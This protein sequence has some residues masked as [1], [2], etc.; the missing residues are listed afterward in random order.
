LLIT[1]TASSFLCLFCVYLC[2]VKKQEL[3]PYIEKGLISER[4]HPNAD[5]WI[6]NYTPVVQYDRL[7]DAITKSCRGLIMDGAGNVIARPFSKFF[8]LQEHQPS[9]IPNEPFDVYEKMDG[10]LGIIY[11]IGNTPYIATRGSFESEQSIH[12]TNVLHT[13]YAH[14]FNKL[15][16]KY[17][18]L[19]EILYPENRIV[20]KD[21]MI[22]AYWLLW[23]PQQ[24]MTFL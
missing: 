2:I 12:A 19:V 3:I 4:K 22:Y 14:L 11:W 5:L 13:R 8:N 6:Y 21:W 15:N 20:I 23:I 18:Y 24:V 7:W 16:R 1:F 17:T 9:E 10:S